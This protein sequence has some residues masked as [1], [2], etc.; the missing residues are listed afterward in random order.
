MTI[1]RLGTVFMA[2]RSASCGQEPYGHGDIAST[3]YLIRGHSTA[4]LFA[5]VMLRK[6]SCTALYNACLTPGGGQLSTAWGCGL[7]DGPGAAQASSRECTA[8]V[9]DWCLTPLLFL[10]LLSALFVCFCVVFVQC[11]CLC[12]VCAV[13]VP[14]HVKFAVRLF[15]RYFPFTSTSKTHTCEHSASPIY[16]H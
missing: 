14:L 9:R 6:T 7:F 8:V 16:P 5:A 1:A 3:L 10:C 11:L 4:R 13:H 2:L 15:F 12:C